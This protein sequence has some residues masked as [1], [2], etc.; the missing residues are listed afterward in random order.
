[1]AVPPP[2]KAE[3]KNK[4]LAT[5][6]STVTDIRHRAAEAVAQIAILE[7][8][9]D[10]WKGIISQLSAAVTTEANSDVLK[11]AA[12][13][14]LSE[15]C[16]G[17]DQKRL[18]DH[19]YDI[20]LAII[21]GMQSRHLELQTVATKALRDAIEFSDKNFSNDE[22][23]GSIMHL[24]LEM[25]K[26]TS[27]EVRL[28]AFETIVVIASAFYEHLP[29]HMLELYDATL[30]AIR[31]DPSEEVVMQAV[32]F[33]STICEVEIMI[34]KENEDAQAAGDA[35]IIVCH[36][37][38]QGAIG[39]L[40]EPLFDTLAKGDVDP[41]VE[42]WNVAAAG[43]ACIALIA[44]TLGNAVVDHFVGLVSANINNPDERK[45]DSSVLCFAS[46]L[47]GPSTEAI[48]QVIFEALPVLFERLADESYLVKHTTA[49][50]LARIAEFHPFPIEGHLDG[51]LTALGNGLT[52]EASVAAK[53]A[54]AIDCLS[55]H[56]NSKNRDASPLNPH[57]STLFNALLV[58][59]DR[60]DSDKASLRLSCYAAV[61]S[62]VYATPDSNIELTRS[63]INLF[64]PRLKDSIGTI[65]SVE[66]QGELCGIL[67]A[68]TRRLNEVTLEEG[69]ASPLDQPLADSLMSLYIDLLNSRPGVSSVYQEV[70][71]AAGTLANAV[72]PHFLNYMGHFAD[73][74][75]LGLQQWNDA[76]LCSQSLTLTTSLC[77][78]LQEEFKNY[79]EPI[80]NT[81]SQHL[82]Q[83]ELKDE[84]GP[85][86]VATYADL[87]FVLG[88]EFYRF[89]SPVMDD[90]S[91]FQELAVK[92]TSRMGDWAAIEHILAWRSSI[93][94]VYIMIV[95]HCAQDHN[96]VV[97]GYLPPMTRLLNAVS[98]DRRDDNVNRLACG[99]IFDIASNYT[100]LTTNL[101][102]AFENFLD[103][104]LHSPSSTLDT[105]N[106]AQDAIDKIAF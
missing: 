103:Y 60:T 37:F 64:A 16:Y 100:N 29:G 98:L 84:L 70:F 66:F 6:Q 50:C 65:A 11:E 76:D 55:A 96:Q 22:Q 91:K 10:S 58:A 21:T 45:R 19:S 24:I 7:L 63:V 42:D 18:A 48:G 67:S 86:I 85:T 71:M 30:N 53:C 33:W 44:S 78:A 89:L 47:D 80:L 9:T 54:D 25:T 34:Y 74:L 61:R 83:P 82:A 56:I 31:T 87:V 1:M 77:F 92:E 20:L 59:S 38:I 97:Q 104:C 39:Q 102:N 35:D 46:I 106:Y 94:S 73:H 99:L 81:L 12:L 52:A 8:P 62:L 17:G 23:R 93:L 57:L 51:F 101:K 79:C 90:L 41:D 13:K 95:Q 69:Q 28:N 14:A 40:A 105:K 32:E 4:L 5:M 75:L 2:A 3:I 68:C 36:N 27:D 43:A 88:P 72:G 15:I 49:W 26:S